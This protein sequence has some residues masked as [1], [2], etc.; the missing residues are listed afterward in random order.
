MATW[1]EAGG[2][3]LAGK[4]TEETPKPELVEIASVGRDLYPGFIG[5][6]LT[7]PDNILSN[8]SGGKRYKLYS[9][10]L[11]KDPHLFACIQT[12]KLGVVSKPWEILP[13][14]AEERNQEICKF[15]QEVFWDIPYFFRDLFELL[16]AIPKGFAVSET[17]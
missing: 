6:V 2:L 11:N 7:N 4:D 16:D 9:E 1:R 15:V 5:K 17:M 3:I 13:F 10:M 12:R 8:E 14:D